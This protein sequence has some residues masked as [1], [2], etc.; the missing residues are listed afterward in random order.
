MVGSGDSVQAVNFCSSAVA[1]MRGMAEAGVIELQEQVPVKG[2]KGSG[3][4]GARQGLTIV[5]AKIINL[6]DEWE[7]RTR[8]GHPSVRLVETGP[9]PD[10]GP[11]PEPEPDAPSVAVAPPQ[12]KLSVAISLLL[13]VLGSAEMAAADVE[14]RE[15]LAEVL[16]ENERLRGRERLLSDQVAALREEVKGLRMLK[17]QLQRN[18]DAVANGAVADDRA[19]RDLDR[20][21]RA[22]PGPVR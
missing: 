1:A 4:G 6:P 2:G 3:R 19:Y 14:V 11:D 18:L 13:D 22:A 17:G 5:G 9:E 15:R 21:V 20:L 12:A 16:A 8:P 7:S 10:P